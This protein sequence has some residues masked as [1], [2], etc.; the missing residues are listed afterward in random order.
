MTSTSWSSINEHTPASDAGTI[1]S[2][3]ETPDPAGG[4][5]DPVP[6]LTAVFTSSLPSALKAKA[7]DASIAAIRV[8]RPADAVRAARGVVERIP[9]AAKLAIKAAVTGRNAVRDARARARKEAVADR[10]TVPFEARIPALHNQREYAY[11]RRIFDWMCR[12]SEQDDAEER[13]ARK[14]AAA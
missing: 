4:S 1:P 7:R 13:A 3:T 14:A 6:A 9:A 10:Y 2:A 12:L 8:I 5:R 11:G